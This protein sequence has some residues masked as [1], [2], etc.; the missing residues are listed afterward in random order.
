LWTAARKGT[1]EDARRLLANGA[2]IEERGGKG[3]SSPLHC[4]ASRGRGVTITRLLLQKGADVSAQSKNGS[5][6]L[7]VEGNHT[8]AL[9]LLEKGADIS[10]KTNQGMTPL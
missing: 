3:K 4:S 7:H 8:V 6:P 10:A 5:T 2:H 9:L 1:M